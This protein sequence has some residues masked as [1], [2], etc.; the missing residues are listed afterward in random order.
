[1]T[2]LHRRS[3]LVVLLC[4]N[5]TCDLALIPFLEHLRDERAQYIAPPMIGALL[6]QFGMLAA[7]L[8][9]GTRSWL[10][11]HITYWFL[12]ILLW[13]ALAYGAAS[14]GNSFSVGSIEALLAVCVAMLFVSVPLP[15]WLIRAITPRRLALVHG[16][17]G[18]VKPKLEQFSLRHLLIWTG[19]A[20][21]LLVVG[22]SRAGREVWGHLPMSLGDTL[23]LLSGMLVIALLCVLVAIPAAWAGLCQGNPMRPLVTAGAYTAVL[24]ATEGTVFGATMG[25]DF[26]WIISGLNFGIFVH[27]TGCALLLR[28]V[29]YRYEAVE[30]G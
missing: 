9:W 22:T 3:V 17:T 26:G 24:T 5:I 12:A 18:I 19:C 7:Y 30:V 23:E 27:V 14:T 28:A 6:G 11:R 8:A 13:Y 29:G 10:V 16:D 1:M 25:D 20:A 2:Q 21:V 15:Y 4:S